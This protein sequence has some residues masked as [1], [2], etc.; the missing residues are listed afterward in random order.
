MYWSLYKT[1]GLVKCLMCNIFR[2]HSLTKP[3]HNADL[4]YKNNSIKTGYENFCI[5][6]GTLKFFPFKDFDFIGKRVVCQKCFQKF[7]S[8]FSYKAH[9]GTSICVR[10]YT[11]P[12]SIYLKYKKKN[13]RSVQ[14]TNKIKYG[15][16]FDSHEIKKNVVNPE[17]LNTL[18]T[19]NKVY[20]N[21][22]IQKQNNLKEK[23]MNYSNEYND[24]S[25]V[26]KPKGKRKK[27]I[28][29]Y[30]VEVKRGRPEKLNGETAGSSN[31]NDN[32]SSG[33]IVVD[34]ISNMKYLLA[35][36]WTLFTKE[37]KS[38]F[39]DINKYQ[40]S[41]KYLNQCNKEKKGYLSAE[42]NEIFLK[43]E[44]L[45]YD[46][47]FLF[48]YF[49]DMKEYSFNNEIQF[50]LT[51]IRDKR[52]EIKQSLLKK[53]EMKRSIPDEGKEN[54]KHTVKKNENVIEI[55]MNNIV[56]D[57]NEKCIGLWI[58]NSY[59]VS[60]SINQINEDNFKKEPTSQDSFED[61]LKPLTIN[62]TPNITNSVKNH[63]NDL[64]LNNI[65]NPTLNCENSRKIF[66]FVAENKLH[67]SEHLVKRSKSF[68]CTVCGLK[69]KEYKHF[70]KH[71]SIHKKAEKKIII[72]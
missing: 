24:K 28:I 23:A 27:D 3:C 40:Y 41:T 60:K 21:N 63:L 56:F 70:I 44:E 25:S 64:G 29:S 8:L 34:I 62:K 66:T 58:N 67:R 13:Q 30:D 35:K 1:I 39:A 15:E 49:K 9:I 36:F 71:D 69:F 59:T 33:Y 42:E 52:D 26:K 16:N 17:M 22:I 53:T 57:K 55:E 12:N 20:S 43:I 6:K 11:G 54:I 37:F 68:V 14:K 10:T 7:A 50:I 5:K 38:N 4:A 65:L 31:Q 47:K 46:F 19:R 51:K 32:C 2:D 18:Q 45:E 72:L 48:K 61:G